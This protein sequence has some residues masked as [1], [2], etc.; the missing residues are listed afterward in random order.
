MAALA[1]GTGTDPLPASPAPRPPETA[2]FPKAPGLTKYVSEF[3]VNTKYADIPADVLELGR[4]SLLDGFGLALAGSASVMAPLVRQYLQNLG[5]N[6]KAAVIGSS[7]KSARALRRLCQWR[8][9]PRRRFRRYPA[10]RG[11]GSRLRLAHPSQ[12]HHASSGLCHVRT[13]AALRQGVHAGLSRGRRSGEQNRRSHSIPAITTTG[14]TPPA[15][16]DR[17]A[18]PPPAPSFADS[19]RCRRPTLSA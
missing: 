7:L 13:R 10:R 15:P 19:T 12:C 2:P 18:A 9:H 16:A 1:A 11:Q 5:V 3:I 14:F 4:K 6:G 17:L 8:L